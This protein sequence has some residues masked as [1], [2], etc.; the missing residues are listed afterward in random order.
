MCTVTYIPKPIGSGYILTSNR[1]ES[2]GRPKAESPR[3]HSLHNKNI[4]FPKDPQAGGTWIATTE[5]D[6]TVC[7][8]NG[9]FTRHEWNPPYRM[10]RGLVLLDFFRF[11]NAFTFSDQ[12][13]EPFTLLITG[14]KERLS[15][16]E[17]RWDGSEIHYSVLNAQKPLIRSS[18]TL[19]DDEVIQKKELLFNEWI[20]KDPH[21]SADNIIDFHSSA[22]FGDP[23]NDFVMNR[24]DKVRT[25]SIT[26]VI[27]ES[28]SGSMKH[29]DLIM[30]DNFDLRIV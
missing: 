19:Y 17:I 18:V 3:K 16:E 25:V 29:H 8:L 20:M 6:Q 7:L 2:P 9:A 26:Q 10:S 14:K 22:G 21:P 24:D 13:D 28:G 23:H 12:Y 30:S 15:I 5:N 27:R 1:D 4:F 11:D